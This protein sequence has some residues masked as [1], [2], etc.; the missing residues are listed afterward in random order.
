ML[1]VY[2]SPLS[3]RLHRSVSPPRIHNIAQAY[4]PPRE[5]SPLLRPMADQPPARTLRDYLTPERGP[6]VS[7]IAIPT[8]TAAN[9]F[10]FKPE[11]HRVIPEFRGREL[12]DPYAHIRE[13]ETIVSTF[14][15]GPGQL[16]QAR[17][18]LFPFSLKDKAKQWFHSLKPRSLLTWSEVQDVFTTKFFPVSR[19]KL[20]M[21]QIQNFKQKDGEVFYKLW[22]RYK[23]LLAAIPHHN[24]PMYLV[25]NHFYLGCDQQAKQLL[26]TMGSGDFM[27]KDPDTAWEFLDAL[28]ERAQSWQYI[29]P[30]DQ[31][32]RNQ[33]PGGSGK[34]SVNEHNVFETR[35]DELSTKLDKMKLDAVHVKEVKE[36]RQLEEVCVI[37]EMVGHSTDNCPTIPA[38]RHHFSQLPPEEACALNQRWDP[39]SNTYNPGLRSNPAFRW[40][41]Q[42]E[43]GSSS[44]SQAP[45]PAQNQNWRQPQLQGPPRFPAIQG[46]PGFQPPGQFQGQNQFQQ[47]QPFPPRRSLED[48]M[49]TFCQMQITT[50]DQTT[51]ALNDMRSQMGKLTTVIGV[52]Q[53]ERGKLPTQPVANPQGQ[54]FAQGSSVPFPEQAK[55]IISL[56]SGKTVDNAQVEPPVAP[57]FLPSPTPSKP[58]IPSEESPKQAPL[59]EETGKSKEGDVP[60]TFTVPAPYP[61]RLRTPAKPNL[62]TDIYD[63]LKQVTVNLPLID[64]IKQ[65]PSYA[66]FLKD[67]CTHKRKLQ[68]QKKVFLTEQVSSLF[69]STLPP[70]YNDP[71]CPTISITIGGKVIEKAL[72][73]LGASV[74]LLPFS[75]YEQLG[76]GEMKPTR[77]TLQLADRSIRIPKGMVEDVLVQVDQFVYPVDFVVL[78]TCPVPAAQSSVP[79]ILGRPF[80]AT[81]DAVI[82]CRDGRLNM[83]F[84]NMK[85]QVNMFHVGSHMG[86]DEDVYGVS[87]IDSL[88]QDHVNEFICKDELEIALTSAEVDFLNAPEVAYMCSLLDEE[89]VC[90]IT[91]WIPKFEELP[92]IEKRA[93][94]S[95][96]EPPT[97]ELKPLPDTL[98]Y[99]YL[100]DGQTYP[101]VVSSALS[102][103]QELELL[104]LLRKH[105]KAIGWSIADI[106]GIE[107]SLCSHHIYLE[108][109]VKPSRQPQRRLNPIMK[110]VV[111][112]EVLKLL[113]VG[114]IYPIA[115]SKWVSPIQVVP[116]KSG[117][118]VVRNDKDELIPTR[119]QTGWRVCIDYR[120][121]NASTRK[122]H[123]PLPFIDQILE[124]V[125]GHKFYCFLDGYSGYNQI[126]VALE[127]QEKTTFTCPF[128]TFAY[129]RMPFGLCNAPGTFSRCIMGL[130]SDMVEK[131]MEVF[132]DD[133]SVF[134]DSFK[135]CLTNLGLVLA[136]CEE[137][138]LVLNWEK[139]HFMVTE[140]IVLGH[141][142]SSKGIEVDRA[143]IDLIGNLPTPKCLKDIRSF[144]GHA[145]FYRRFIKDFSFIARPL[146]HLLAKDV[147]FEW[148]PACEAAFTKLKSSLTSP[149]IVRSPDWEL[150]F[151]LMCDASDYAVGAVLGQRQGKEPYVI[152]YASKTLN[153]AQMNYSTTE[154]ELLAIVFALDKF[155]SY[156][157]GAP[158]TVYTDHSALKYLFTKQD[159]KARLIRWILLLQEFD[160]TIKD[161]KG[162]ENVVADHLSRLEFED[163]TSHIPIGDSFPDEQLFAISTTP[164]Y[165]DIVNYLVTV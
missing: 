40:N 63:V 103:L 38:L 11:Y 48:T 72:L 117:V 25:I 14:V 115:D 42:N 94:P 155:R 37:C 75:V 85:M 30:G 70:K 4:S 34:F 58:P 156:L 23:D 125:A 96:V 137:K 21:D 145:G 130:F 111:R 67:L 84:G 132:M 152:Y 13:F 140:G 64:A 71:G 110:D 134:G 12:E 3:K 26:D 102:E 59:E 55:A 7:P 27:G 47:P 33:G 150:P 32:M 41:N 105:S 98:K 160:L 56:R 79:I 86:D 107:A 17:L 139:C 74:N 61:N 68:V 10:A 18:K 114:I 143:K 51:Q 165:A 45:P 80:L 54:H 119:V 15:T 109:D 62:N 65:I 146:C 36:V 158:I 92:P 138:N 120:K 78:D 46:P 113:D 161:K 22:E 163:H 149:P 31:A 122:D 106:K 76:L 60:Q 20:L 101:V 151:E 123:F 126:E 144:L 127:D 90:G 124:R 66:K 24:L 2:R 52:L 6:H 164:W 73:D 99:A 148:T 50:N 95:S 142:V 147:P 108:D 49:N 77:V 100:G 39:Y 88:V 133:F 159:A 28:A 104:V 69:E 57:S 16:D 118:T 112:A 97:L 83:S 19:T 91:P 81:S 1:N 136:R 157:V 87:M 29:D 44:T 82:H 154:K 93:V 153:E 8:C 162:V 131:I 43:A 89:E 116:K 5:L 141:I 135:A 53:Q 128:G 35:L 121:L 129:R 9:A